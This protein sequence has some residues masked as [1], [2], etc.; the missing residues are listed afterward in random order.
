M[1][2]FGMKLV[3][4]AVVVFSLVCA[5]V[6][7]AA[8]M[9]VREGAR[10][11]VREAP[12][13]GARIVGMA[14]SSDY[15]EIFE[16]QSDWSRIKTPQGEEGWVS[17]RFLTKQMP[18]ELI[19]DQLGER[20][21]SLTNE[22]RALQEENTQLRKQTREHAYR[23]SGQSKEVEDAKKQYDLLKQ[24]SSHYLDLKSKHEALQAEFKTSSER[25][26]SLDRENRRLKTSRGSSSPWWEEASSSSAWS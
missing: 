23:I 1:S 24:E 17:N 3:F 10:A 12:H 22:N 21:K 20:I 19:I 5:Q 13:E 26:D 9:Y 16:T 7:F 4:M 6:L 2:R 25:L 11:A 8:G 18:K 14:G 15:L